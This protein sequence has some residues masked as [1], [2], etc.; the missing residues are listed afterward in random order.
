M[1]FVNLLIYFLLPL[2]AIGYLFLMK[3]YSYF[4]DRDIPHM[5][6]NSLILGSLGD[7]GKKYHFLDFMKVVYNKCKDK[8]GV[9]GYYSLFLPTFLV[10]DLEIVKQITVKD[11]NV[12]TDRGMYVNE[13]VEPISGHLFSIEGEKWRFLRNKLS[14]AFTSGKIKMM[15]NTIADKGENFI[16][17][18]D[19]ASKTGSVNIKNIATRF[20]VDVISSCAFG[21]E[22][23]T[24][25]TELHE[26]MEIL[27]K[28]T[29][30]GAI[31]QFR[32]IFIAALPK[33]AKLLKLRLFDRQVNDFF[34]KMVR[35]SMEFREDNKVI[36]NDFMNMLIQ[37]K[38]KGS[39]DGETS[40]STKK[41]TMNECI[42][43][44][45]VFFLGG[46]ETSSFVISFAMLEL[47]SH[48][49]IQDKLRKEILEKTK[50]NNGEIT[51]ENLQEM[52]YLYQVVNG[53]ENINLS[54]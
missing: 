4:K 24:L 3:K 25:D 6:R 30:E 7:V 49:E 20:T 9:C 2:L 53:E 31:S 21:I 13:E 11:F 39:I 42:A 35:G 46:A 12:F 18:L 8:G 37:L 41:L 48:P 40:T 22:A 34:N 15:Y 28:I 51:Y 23:N 32:G 1:F 16:T 47:G 14:P 26:M 38:N 33:L 10:T 52:S 45:F 19:K 50:S 5:E 36:R 29:G 27:K 54:S 43:Q 44:A 17:A